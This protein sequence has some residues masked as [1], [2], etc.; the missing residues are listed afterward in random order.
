MLVAA[1]LVLVAVAV[2]VPAAATAA[3][4]IQAGEA[5]CLEAARPDTTCD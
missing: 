4:M 1:S 2:W 5:A 3:Q